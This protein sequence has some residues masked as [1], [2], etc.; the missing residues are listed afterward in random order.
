LKKTEIKGKMNKICQNEL[1][2]HTRATAP[3]LT[4]SAP[5]LRPKLAALLSS[6]VVLKV[7]LG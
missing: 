1:T 5:A 2:N 6:A 7:V 4:V 3:V